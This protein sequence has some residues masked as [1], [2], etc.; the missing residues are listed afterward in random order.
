MSKKEYD[1][2]L[3][4]DDFFVELSDSDLIDDDWDSDTDVEGGSCAGCCDGCDSIDPD[5][6]LLGFVAAQVA[7]AEQLKMQ[8]SELKAQVFELELRL[9]TI[10]IYLFGL[11]LVAV[12]LPAFLGGV[13]AIVLALFALD[14]VGTFLLKRTAWFQTRWYLASDYIASLRSGR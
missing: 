6:E 9:M 10:S 7:H 5:E 1:G 11:G 13:L 2:E 4:E 14:T 8:Q 3:T 12:L